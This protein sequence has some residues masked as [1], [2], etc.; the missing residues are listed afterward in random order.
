MIQRGIDS[1]VLHT[2]VGTTRIDTPLHE[3]RIGAVHR[4]P[5]PRDVKEIKWASFD[6]HLLMLAGSKG[7]R[8]IQGRVDGISRQDGG[9]ELQVRGKDPERYDLLTVATGVNTAALKMLEG[10]DLGYRAPRTTKAAIR[11]YRLGGERIAE[12]LGPSSPRGTTRPCASS[13]RTSTT[14]SSRSS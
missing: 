11:E 12:L 7:A 1:Y 6:A 2:D 3:M 5:G 9:F 10:L 8:L 4:G 14:L 13:G